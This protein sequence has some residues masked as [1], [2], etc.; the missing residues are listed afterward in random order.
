LKSA[1]I[2]FGRFNPFTIGH[3]KL[4]QA[5]GNQS[6]HD[7]FVYMSH[8]FDAVKNPLPYEEKLDIVT[9]IVAENVPKVEV[10]ESNAKTFMQVLNELTGKYDEIYLVVGSDR[11]VEFQE[12]VDKYNGI[13]D[14]KGVIPFSFHSVQ[15]VSAGERDPDAE[16]VEGMSATK[17]R[18]AATSNDFESFRAGFPSRDT[19]F[20]K[21]VFQR[22]RHHMSLAESYKRRGLLVLEED[23]AIKL[24][25]DDGNDA[26]FKISDDKYAEILKAG[27]G[28]KVT[29]PDKNDK[30]KTYTGTPTFK[31]APDGSEE[32]IPWGE[33][34]ETP[35]KTTAEKIKPYADIAKKVIDG[36]S[37]SRELARKFNEWVQQPSPDAE[38]STQLEHAIVLMTSAD[39]PTLQHL[40]LIKSLQEQQESFEFRNPAKE[41][42]DYRIGVDADPKAMKT[43][44]VEKYQLNQIRQEAGQIPLVIVVNQL[45]GHLFSAAQNRKILS[46]V[47]GQSQ[48]PQEQQVSSTKPN[49]QITDNT[50]SNEV[51]AR[52]S[53]IRSFIQSLAEAP[54]S[55]NRDLVAAPDQQAT[56][57]TQEAQPTPEGSNS[58]YVIAAT[59]Y[60][61]MIAKLSK[62]IKHAY[63]VADP[64]NVQSVYNTIAPYW[65]KQ[66]NTLYLLEKVPNITIDSPNSLKEALDPTAD[67]LKRSVV[68]LEQVAPSMEMKEAQDHKVKAPTG[69]ETTAL[70]IPAV[71]E[72]FDKNRTQVL[73][74]LQN[75]FAK[76][77]QGSPGAEYAKGA[78]QAFFDAYMK[79]LGLDIVST[80]RR[81]LDALSKNEALM[82]VANLTGIPQLLGVLNKVVKTASGRA[83]LAP[84]AGTKKVAME[85]QQQTAKESIQSFLSQRYQ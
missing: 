80:L 50:T 25:L 11:V 17:M 74:A 68:G 15:V 27:K 4:V 23:V 58:V 45:E 83:T 67:S 35:D 85:P 76:V 81:G 48:Q 36:L 16:G 38:V 49:L 24:K 79:S 46:A 62:S 3:L 39:P 32:E 2:T 18:Q 71:V 28:A 40:Q 57:P 7:H 69:L 60:Q 44:N 10:I 52:E 1:A 78:A 6:A 84:K 53:T 73:K 13:P 61:G 34:Q 20:A 64:S 30:S 59:D 41:T 22:V 37:T 19:R 51:V 21:E 42:R 12:S 5:V 75:H 70:D 66:G 43:Q 26:T 54:Q 9:K 82:S 77:L 8:S 72:E 56:G 55:S 33:S 14:K 63:F 47:F 29:L 31:L 65:A